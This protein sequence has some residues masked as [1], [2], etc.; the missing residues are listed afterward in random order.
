MVTSLLASWYFSMDQCSGYFTT[1]LGVFPLEI[2]V[3]GAMVRRHSD[4]RSSP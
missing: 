2:V 3:S 1:W 4:K